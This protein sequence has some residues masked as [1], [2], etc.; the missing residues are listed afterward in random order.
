MENERSCFLRNTWKYDI[1]CIVGK[2][3]ISFSY[4]YGITLPIKKQISSSPK[5]TVPWK[6]D[7]FWI[8]VKM[9]FLF[10]A[11]MMLPFCQ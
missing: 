10:P 11:T 9:V 8:F 3:G 4:K 5:N 7:I 2:D 1:F 6:Y